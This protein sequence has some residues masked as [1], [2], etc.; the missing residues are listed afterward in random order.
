VETAAK[1]VVY[2]PMKRADAR[3]NSTLGLSR[4]EWN[5]SGAEDLNLVARNYP[6][7]PGKPE[8]NRESRRCAFLC[9]S[10]KNFVRKG[11]MIA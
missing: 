1:A 2:V 8:P 11:L 10:S 9:R 3:V 5:T 6:S 4:R 7:R